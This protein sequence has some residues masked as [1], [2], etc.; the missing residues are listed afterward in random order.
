MRSKS[1][2]IKTWKYF[3]KKESL[4]L[5]IGSIADYVLSRIPKTIFWKRNFLIALKDRG[6]SLEISSNYYDVLQSDGKR[7]RLRKNSSDLMV[8]K[9]HWIREELKFLVELLSE[10]EIKVQR[11]IDAGANIGLATAYLKTH[12]PKAAVICIEPD[13]SN[14]HQLKVNNDL[15]K[16]DEISFVKGGIWACKGMLNIH[17]NFRDGKEWAR[18]LKPA[19]NGNGEIPVFR[20][21]DILEQFGWEHADLLKIDVEGAEEVIFSSTE[22][23]SF[24]KRIKV[25]TIEVHDTN[26]TGNIILKKLFENNFDVFFSGELWIGINSDYVS[27]G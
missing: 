9:Q 24:L 25:I 7:F 16:L 21:D 3:S 18:S 22:S 2:L 17:S 4:Q 23:C 5:V 15:N 19:E 14:F 8:Y 27:L 1:G 26:K 20:I 13:D 12:F 6:N 10:K 11:I